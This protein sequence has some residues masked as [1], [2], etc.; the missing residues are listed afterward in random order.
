MERDEVRPT[1]IYSAKTK[2]RRIV[3]LFYADPKR[4]AEPFFRVV[5]KRLVDFSLRKITNTDNIYSVE[6]FEA[7]TDMFDE[8]FRNDPEIVKLVNPYTRKTKWTC[9]VYDQSKL[10]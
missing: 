5:T 3:V 9:S 2:N 6:T 7:L 8:A 4:K 10:K 1:K